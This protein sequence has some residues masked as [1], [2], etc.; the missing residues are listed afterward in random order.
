MSRMQQRMQQVARRARQLVRLYGLSWFLALA[1]LAAVLAGLADYWIRFEDLGVRLISFGL[2][3]LVVA[4]GFARFVLVAWRYRCSVLQ[5]ARKIEQLHP[6]LGDRLTSAVAFAAESDDDESWGS[7]QLRRAVVTETEAATEGIDFSA[8]LDRRPSYRALA[9]AGVV[10]STIVVLA[11]L[12]GP[13]VALAARRLLVPWGHDVW[14]RRH[15]LQWEQAPTRLAIGQDFEARL[16]DAGGSL[17]PR[18]EIQYWFEGDESS[19]IQS[20]AMKP[21]EGQMVHRLAN[22]TRPFRYR[23]AGGDDQTM[24]W[25]A[26]QLVEPPRITQCALTLHPPDYAGGAER[27]VDGGFRALAGTRVTLHG[28]TSKPLTGATLETDTVGGPARIPLELDS[29]RLGF[30]LDEQ[31]QAWT[32]LQS[33]VYGIRL[34]DQ[35]GLDVGVLSQWDVHVQRD[36]P[37]TVSLRQPVADLMVTPQARVKLA[38][39]VKDDLAVRAVSLHWLHSTDPEGAAQVTALWTGP[40]RVNVPSARDLLEEE[41]VQATIQQVW[42]LASLGA[43]SPGQWLD[44][45]VTAEDYKGQFGESAVRRL[46]LISR[47][48]L[49]DRVGQHYSELLDEI[50]E[51]VRLQSDTRMQVWGLEIQAREA[52]QFA[53]QDLDQLQAAELNQRQ[54]QQRLSGTEDGVA[55]EILQLLEQLDSNRIENPELA[56]RL[57]QVQ[58]SLDQLHRTVLNSL[59]HQLVDAIKLVRPQAVQADLSLEPAVR[60]ELLELFPP[61]LAGQQQVIDQLSALLGRLAQWDSYQRLAR[62]VGRLKREQEELRSHTQQLRIETLSGDP[63]A[64]TAQQRA[65]LKRLTQRQNDVALQFDTLA[66]SMDKTRRELQPDDPLVAATL[67]DALAMIRNES[68]GG[69]IRDVGRELDRKRLG[70][71][72]DGQQ[73]VVTLLTRLQ[74]LLAKRRDVQPTRQA[75]T[76]SDAARTLQGIRDRQDALLREMESASA[77]SRVQFEDWARR[78]QQLADELQR[79]EREL[80]NGGLQAA[81][82]AMR[83]ARQAL[84]RAAESARQQD[85]TQT[86]SAARD[87]Q[88]A[89]EQVQQRIEAARQALTEALQDQQAQRLQQIVQDLLTRQQQLLGDTQRAELLRPSGAAQPPAQWEDA[90]RAL[91][92]QQSALAKEVSELAAS[93]THVLMFHFTLDTTAQF[94]DRAARQLEQLQTGADAT[95]WQQRAVDQLQQLAAAMSPD[96]PAQKAQNPDQEATPPDAQN[97]GQSRTKVAHLL[98]QLKLVRTLQRQL[99]DQTQALQAAA[100]P[101]NDQVVGQHAEVVRQQQRLAAMVEQLLE[102][103]SAEPDQQPDQQPGPAPNGDLDALERALQRE[104]GDGQ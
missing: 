102:S 8:C 94:M 74:D 36:S 37:P 43:M 72:V 14:P 46:L 101:W 89:L 62:E 44:F 67:A 84:G 40:A 103:A 50:A 25:T 34:V 51:V 83:A 66:T 33:G 69:V 54:V 53:Q 82:E 59:Q 3:C 45:H 100:K 98:A 93:L 75:E 48:E 12:D 6:E 20:Y 64:L 7:T 16:S 42:D 28:R 27:H 92:G 99:N 29:D 2:L 47:E 76:F 30:S 90:T 32:V 80:E 70:Q 91:A 18:V 22:V 56:T 95:Q 96:P 68:I 55:G 65:G 41:G 23:A 61:V 21:V 1:C 86:R 9:A 78:Q 39:I 15:R 31:S 87:A 5:A 104:E 13:S 81:A 85:L 97:D 63:D 88:Q 49:E 24:S 4:W 77:P 52:E 38:A 60:E 73:R 19:Q 71:A 35:Q 58:A 57:R 17:P 11:A 10:L 79:L 26:L